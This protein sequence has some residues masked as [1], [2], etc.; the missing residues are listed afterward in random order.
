MPNGNGI[1]KSD[2]QDAIDSAID[3]L[4]AVYL[5]ES[6]REEMAAGIAEALSALE[7]DDTSNDDSDDDYA[8]GFRTGIDDYPSI[9]LLSDTKGSFWRGYCDGWNS[10]YFKQ[11]G[12][13]PL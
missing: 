12:E 8:R 9:I 11:Y 1:T 10:M 13:Y 2:L 4:E 5:P 6:T 7:G 3:A